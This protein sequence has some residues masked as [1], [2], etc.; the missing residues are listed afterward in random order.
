MR[1]RDLLL[2]GIAL[3]GAGVASGWVYAAPSAAPASTAKPAAA[4]AFEASAVR[5]NAQSLAQAP[6]AIKD[7]KLPDVLAKLSYDDYRK[8]RFDADRSLWRG[9]GRPYEAQFFHRGFLYKDRVQIF[10]VADGK[11]TEIAYAPELFRTDD[12][13][14]PAQADQGFAGF[15][16]HGPIN[17][18]DYFDEICAFLGAS[19][20]RAV[21][22]G[23]VYG[24]SARGLAIKTASAEGEEFPAFRSFWIERPNPGARSIVV[25]A[26]LDSPSAAA[27]YRFSVTPQEVTTLFDVEM[28]LYP[29]IDIAEAGIAP[30]TSMFYFAAN[31]R[32]GVDDFRPAVHDSDGLAIWSGRGEQ[33]WRP[34]ANPEEL[35]VSS[36][37]DDGV[38][39]FGLMQR[40]RHFSDFKDVEARYDQRPSLWVE[41]V[42]NWGKGAVHLVEIPTKSEI[43]DNIVASWRPAV[44]LKAKSEY[45]FNY[46]LHWCS[47]NPGTTPLATVA[48]TMIGGSGREGS[49]LVVIE[50]TGESLRNLPDG[51]QFQVEVSADKGRTAFPVAHPNPITGGWRMSF[52]FMPDDAKVVE[53]RAVL[54]NEGQPVSETWIYRWTA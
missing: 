11:A 28:V 23:Q 12:L 3:A 2:G 54:K 25:H 16:L 32:I 5:R 48:E 21:A 27:A 45:I 15:R 38:R 20:F 41:P 39:G 19:Y 9:S 47:Q 26:L 22:K 36:F 49:R 51:K 37:V 1:R 35:Q 4:T 18:L 7:N 30:L 50:L 17:K 6:Y 31:D 46:R 53:L 34:L 13:Q 44:P 33:L 10:E 52:E 40:R 29:R 42:G 8:I 43:H 24:L 14:L